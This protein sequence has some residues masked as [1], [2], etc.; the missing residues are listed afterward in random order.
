MVLALRIVV[1]IFAILLAGVV[2]LPVLI[3]LWLLILVMDV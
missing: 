2:V 3:G 1:T